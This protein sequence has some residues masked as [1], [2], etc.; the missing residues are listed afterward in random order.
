MSNE[1]RGSL[2]VPVARMSQELEMTPEPESDQ[3]WPDIVAAQD[4]IIGHP[5]LLLAATV[6][7]CEDAIVSRNL[8]GMVTSWNSAAVRLFGYA[9]E[10]MIGQP[11]FRIIPKELHPAEMEILRRV[12]E[13]E[14]IENYET[15]RI[16]KDGARLDVSVCI[17]PIDDYLES[18]I[19]S[20]K[21]AGGIARPELDEPTLLHLAAIVESAQDAIIG[22]D[23]DGAIMSWNA[24][25][26]T[27]FGYDEQEMIGQS[28]LKLVP[29]QLLS[30]EADVL[31]KLQLGIRIEHLS[32]V[33]L[34]KDGS[35]V[36]VSLTISPIKDA[37]GRVIGCS[38]IARDISVEKRREE[39][40]AHFSQHD[41]L[42]GLPNRQLMH[43]RLGMMLAQAERNGYQCAVM[44]LDL[45]GFKAINDRH[46]H[47]GGD[48]LLV[49]TASRLKSVLRDVDTV[50]RMGGDE[51]VILISNL[52]GP[53]DALLVAEKLRDAL[54]KPFSLPNDIAATIGASIGICMNTPGNQD[55]GTL[56]R[57]ADTAMYHAKASEGRQI[58]FYSQE[59]ARQEFRRREIVVAM[60]EALQT[61]GFSLEYQPIVDMQN[62][63]VLGFECLIR[64]HNRRVGTVPPNEFI[65]IAEETGLIRPI[66]VWMIGKACRAIGELNRELDATFF[67]SVNLSPKQ[68]QDE[69][70]LTVIETALKDNNLGRGQLEI[71]ITEGLLTKE[72][73]D[74]LRFLHALR[75]MGVLI[76]IDDFGTGFSNISYLWHFPI[77]RLKLDRSIV[78]ARDSHADSA[79]VA[80]AIIALA[81]QLNISVIA[82]GIETPEQ[83]A[84]I[85]E[86]ACDLGQGYYFAKPAPLELHKTFLSKP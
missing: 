75:S 49:E 14:R 73:P 61:E 48:Q 28:I 5:A 26:S 50:S 81:H 43:D 13:G 57:M 27:M 68:F 71:E 3:I 39:Q 8:R 36:D 65:P 12:G 76:D 24:A 10:E 54:G 4:D 7:T 82:E 41:Q 46:G 33:R 66:G 64:M 83:A 67:I 74:I 58:E 1:G 79:A 32:T 40:L 86:A 22:K 42:T 34:R 9:A 16:R 80:K 21:I 77:D 11:I 59:I 29:E 85:K 55:G 6:E 30:E 37:S 25:A 45:N 63:S 60:Q 70:L 56:L 15:A 2:A 18:V 51:F 53:Q 35:K 69:A 44:V 17:S 84:V 78:G 38:T 47:Q 20:S 23:L 19:G 31:H 62:G 52:H 72:S